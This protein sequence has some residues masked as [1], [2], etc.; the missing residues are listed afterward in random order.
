MGEN[1]QERGIAKQFS[2]TGIYGIVKVMA[3]DRTN[4]APGLYSALRGELDWIWRIIQCRTIIFHFISACENDNNKKV[5]PFF[6]SDL[7]EKA[8]AFQMNSA[9]IIQS[10]FQHFKAIY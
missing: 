10:L 3:L 6:L 8:D 1:E 4:T 2:S 5:D 9:Q 7:S